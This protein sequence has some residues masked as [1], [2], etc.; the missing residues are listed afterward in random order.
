MRAAIITH[1][2]NTF[3]YNACVS[4]QK[5]KI[6]IPIP[7]E[8]DSAELA[9]PVPILLPASATACKASVNS[10]LIFLADSLS[11]RVFL[12]NSGASLSI[13]PYKS[14]ARPFGPTL[15]KNTL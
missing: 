12:A 1:H 6:P 8:P 3:S 5:I 10:D 9:E 13:V 4:D 14:Q 7:L 2:V 11:Y 15:T